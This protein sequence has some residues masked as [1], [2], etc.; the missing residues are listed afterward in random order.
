MPQENPPLCISEDVFDYASDDDPNFVPCGD[1]DELDGE[2]EGI[3]VTEPDFI[4]PPL[5]GKPAT[6]EIKEGA[7]YQ[8]SKQYATS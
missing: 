5:Q 3:D 8:R 6:S 1:L 4:N 2:E 7:F